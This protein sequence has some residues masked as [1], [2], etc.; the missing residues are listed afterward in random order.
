[1]F[2]YN[3]NSNL[4][5]YYFGNMTSSVGSMQYVYNKFGLLSEA[6]V[7]E[8]KHI[9]PVVCIERNLITNGSGSINDPYIVR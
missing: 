8:K 6:K 4:N 3:S 2:D 5:D 7:T 1:M 9:V